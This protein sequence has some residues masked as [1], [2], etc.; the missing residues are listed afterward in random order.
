MLLFVARSSVIVVCDYYAVAVRRGR[1]NPTAPNP[2]GQSL[3]ERCLDEEHRPRPLQGL[4]GWALG[5]SVLLSGAGVSHLAAPGIYE[6][7]VPHAL[8]GSRLGWTVV[9]GI[10]ELACATLVANHSTRRTGSALTAVL[11]VAVFPANIQMA[12]DWRHHSG[13]DPFIA[14]GRLPIQMVL[15][16]WALHVRRTSH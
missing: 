2:S 9:S 8:P 4:D 12:L 15:V 16:L 11:F 14:Y 5:L 10:A 7:I 6:D 3:L 13:L 1:G